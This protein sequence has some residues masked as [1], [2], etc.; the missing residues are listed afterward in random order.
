MHTMNAAQ[1]QLEQDVMEFRRRFAHLTPE[2]QQIVSD[3]I[4]A[5]YATQQIET[6]KEAT[7]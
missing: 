7:E 2:N 4:A 6:R 5:L 1:T 3:K